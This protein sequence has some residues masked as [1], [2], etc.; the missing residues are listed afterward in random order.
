MRPE[1]EGCP[2]RVFADV[3]FDELP[4][5]VL[6]QNVE[7]LFC[8]KANIRQKRLMRNFSLP[9]ASRRAVRPFLFVQLDRHGQHSQQG[10]R[11]YYR[12]FREDDALDRG[13]GRRGGMRDRAVLNGQGRFDDAAQK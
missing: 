7:F 3:P 13:G 5:R 4:G 1:A 9:N 6:R 10:V 11:K 8:H 12:P 2:G